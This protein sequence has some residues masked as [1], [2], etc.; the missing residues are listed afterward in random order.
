MAVQDS[1]VEGQGVNT[2]QTG[3]YAAAV[4]KLSFRYNWMIFFSALALLALVICLAGFQYLSERAR[5]LNEESSRVTARAADVEEVL[6]GVA[7]QVSRMKMWAEN[8]L[9]S[10]IYLTRTTP[11][12]RHL[13]RTNTAQN[14]FDLDRLEPPFNRRNTGKIV[15]AGN[16]DG[17]ESQLYAQLDMAMELFRLQSAFRVLFPHVERTYFLSDKHFISCFPWEASPDLMKLEG[18]NLEEAFKNIYGMKLW[19]RALPEINPEK[20]PYWTSV[21]EDPGTKK[22]VVTSGVPVYEGD[23]FVGMIG[24]DISIGLLQ[25]MVEN[26]A[27]TE[28]QFIVVDTDGNVLADSHWTGDFPSEP[29]HLST[30]LPAAIAEQSNKFIFSAKN[31][32]YSSGYNVIVHHFD[33]G[34]MIAL[35]VIPEYQLAARFLPTFGLY[36]AVMLG[37]TVFLVG[38]QMAIRSQFVKPAISVAEFMETETVTGRA[39]IP[40]VPA[41]WRSLFEDLAATFKL[42]EVEWHLRSF[43]ESAS[44]FVVY[45]FAVEPETPGKSRVRFVSPSIREVMG[46]LEPYRVETWFDN[47]HPEDRERVVQASALALGEGRPF[48]QIMRI[49]HAQRN[50]WAWIHARSVPVFDQNGNISCFNGLIID[51]NELRKAEKDLEKELEKFQALYGLTTAMTADRSL[52]DNLS[53]IVDTTRRLFGSDVSHLVMRNDETGDM[54]ISAQ[55]GAQTEAFKKLRIPAGRGMAGKVA[56]MEKGHIV[57]DYFAQVD[58]LLHDVIRNEGLISGMAVPVQIGSVSLGV[59]FAVNRK[60]TSFTESD[61]ET[62]NLIGKLAAMEISRKTVELQ[63]QKSRD[64][65]EKRVQERTSALVD[66]NKKLSREI[67]ERKTAEAALTASEKTLRTIF[68][69]SRD[70]IFLHTVDGTMVDVNESLL[71]TYGVSSRERALQLSIIWDYSSPDNP[72][73]LLPER[74]R[75]VMEGEHQFFEWK[76]RR[77]D[78]GSVFDVEVFLCKLSTSSGDLILANVHDFS[79]RKKIETQLRYQKAFAEQLFQNSPDA[80]AAISMEDVVTGINSAFTGLFGYE[81]REALGRNINDLVVPPD[82]REQALALSRAGM[83]GESISGFEGIRRHRNGSRI[84]V[85]LVGSPIRVDGKQV[86]FFAM[87]RDISDRIGALKALHRS[88]TLYRTLVESMPYGIVETDTEGII[89]FSNSAYTRLTGYDLQELSRMSV[90]DILPTEVDRREFI[91]YGKKILK[92]EPSPQTWFGRITK[93]NKQ[94]FDVQVDWNYRR[95]DSGKLIGF[96]TIYTDITDRKRAEEA[97]RES[98]EKYRLVVEHASEGI[99]IFQDSL[100]QYANPR[101]L[102]ITG[103][104]EYEIISTPWR[105]LVH[106]EDIGSAGRYCDSVELGTPVSDYVVARIVTKDGMAKWVRVSAVHILW[107]GAPATLSFVTDVTETKKMEEDLINIEKLESIGMLAGGIAHDFNNLLTAILGNI[108]LARMGLTPEDRRSLTL[109]EAEKACHRARG[110]TQQLLAFSKGGAPI[111]RAIHLET[112]VRETCEFC[113]RGTNCMSIVNSVADAWMVEADPGQLGQVFTNLFINACQAMPTGGTIETIIEN[114]TLK[115]SDGLALQEGR[116]VRVSVRDSGSGISPQHQSKIFAPYFSTKPKGSGLGLAA[117]YAV[118]RNHDGLI[119]V[120]SLPGAGATF[121]VYLPASLP[122]P[123]ERLQTLEPVG[124]EVEQFG[125]VLVMDDDEA[126]RSLVADLLSMM[127]YEIAVARDGTECIALYEAALAEGAPYSVVILDLT[128]P[129]GMGGE[130]AIKRLLEIDP[131]VTAIVSSGYSD[132]PIMSEYRRYGFRGVISKPYDVNELLAVLEAVRRR[133]PNQP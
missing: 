56:Q 31:V 128:V 123:Q 93:K 76:A 103:Y 118:V 12:L 97:L 3:K 71:K 99:V 117:A 112:L 43:M 26:Q 19:K 89:K 54:Y 119:T 68:N 24:A 109:E 108:S 65:L 51:I 27:E 113:V 36:L 18:D 85:S 100:V 46:I 107:Q 45:Q 42:K 96:M 22:A 32:H 126:I 44:G 5:A 41:Q 4:R 64:E 102:E 33:S 122:Q 114:V 80:I 101:L 60:K 82:Q 66:A 91:R 16:L 6:R 50:E 47:I 21:Y 115:E 13:L 49:F 130:E 121:R 73:E 106:R 95:D 29:R 116:Y 28:G 34:P 110:L 7:T 58:P 111:K 86:G 8:N 74:W 37:L 88:E 105:S 72:L 38:T 79:E 125:K 78:D 92:N 57:E 10:G 77:P 2:G 75:K 39:E 23:V 104:S 84:D 127:G 59:L 120:E 81:E 62:L 133:Q 9:G 132:A 11:R 20:L 15:G 124:E 40:D 69:S 52:D 30:V 35:G 61:L 14:Y 53:L 48:D 131:S 83:N 87:Y 17:R 90:L 98:E 129:G 63:L 1:A 55:S 67:K 70:P 25:G 94:I